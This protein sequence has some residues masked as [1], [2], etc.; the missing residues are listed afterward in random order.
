[1]PNTDALAALREQVSQKKH[2]TQRLDQLYAQQRTLIPQTRALKTQLLKEQADVERLEEGSLA[3]FFYLLIGQKEERLDKE[4]E[5]AYAAQLKYDTAADQLSRIEADIQQTRQELTKLK[6][7]ER[8]YQQALA[9]KKQALKAAGSQAAEEL[10]QA[11]AQ[12]ASLQSQKRELDEA[13][14][15]G[16]AALSTTSQVLNSLGSAKGWG[17]WDFIGGGLIADV[18]K[19]SH[20]NDAQNYVYQLQNDLRRF[21][22]ELADV[23]L[24][25]DLQVNISGFLHFAD[26]FFDGLIADWMVLKRIGQSQDQVENLQYQIQAVLDNLDGQRRQTMAEFSQKQAAFEKLLETLPL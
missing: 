25:A 20:L 17:T 7:C 18:V 9:E 10:L 14:S 6:D 13:I 5:E 3:A 19:H 16:Q 1:M 21:Q 8:A 12:L 2:L 15:A 11:E 23:T 4:R 22:T 24:S 26:Y